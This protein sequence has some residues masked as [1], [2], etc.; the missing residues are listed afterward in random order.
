MLL[1]LNI[2]EWSQVTRKQPDWVVRSGTRHPS[3][4]PSHCWYPFHLERWGHKTRWKDSYCPEPQGS[5]NTQKAPH[6]KQLSKLTWSLE[7]L[8]IGSLSFPFP[9][10]KLRHSPK[11][12]AASPSLQEC[13][14]ANVLWSQALSS[15]A[16]HHHH[17]GAGPSVT[18]KYLATEISVCKLEPWESVILPKIP[19]CFPVSAQH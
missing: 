19:T 6:L 16:G 11:R 2:N 4:P 3:P 13:Q 8:D 12:R 10:H 7:V 14:S 18:V 17:F 9:A 15:D 5:A 1:L